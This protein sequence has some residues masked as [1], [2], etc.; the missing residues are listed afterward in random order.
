MADGSGILDIAG[1]DLKSAERALGPVK[2]SGKTR[3]AGRTGTRIGYSASGLLSFTVFVFQF[4]QQLMISAYSFPVGF[5]V[6]F[7]WRVLSVPDCFGLL[8][9]R[10]HNILLK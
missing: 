4:A 7:V 8:S 1:E 2:S 9:F 3:G 5:P 6:G 10:T